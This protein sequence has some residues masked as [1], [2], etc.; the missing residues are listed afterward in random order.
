M[1]EIGFRLRYFLFVSFTYRLICWMSKRNIL[2]KRLNNVL[3]LNDG[4]PSCN[5]Q[6]LASAWASAQKATGRSSAS[7]VLIPISV[8]TSVQF[9]IGLT[10]IPGRAIFEHQTDVQVHQHRFRVQQLKQLVQIESALVCSYVKAVVPDLNIVIGPDWLAEHL[11]GGW[12]SNSAI[13]PLSSDVL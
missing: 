8:Y 11:P 4:I 2:A 1:P 10:L 13:D 3:R 9:A 12:R 6:M 5:L 7:A